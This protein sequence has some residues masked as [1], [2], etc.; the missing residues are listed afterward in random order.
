MT[1]RKT[2]GNPSR[3]TAADLSPE[4]GRLATTVM[5]NAG[6]LDD[7]RRYAERSSDPAAHT[8]LAAACLSR[9]DYETAR[10]AY[11][12]ALELGDFAPARQGAVNLLIYLAAHAAA[13]EE[14]DQASQHLQEAI[15]AHPENPVVRRYSTAVQTAALMRG[16]SADQMEEA[17]PHLEKLQL[18]EPGRADLAHQLAMMYHRR[19]IE[20]EGTNKAAKRDRAWELAFAN[21]GLVI[22]SDEYWR[23]WD[24]A[25]EFVYEKQID[26]AEVEKLRHETIGKVIKDLHNQYIKLYSDRGQ[27]AHLERHKGLRAAWALELVMARALHETIK[28]LQSKNRVPETA[29]ACG[30]LMWKHL[31]IVD[32]VEAT[33]RA[34]LKL[35]P[36]FPA[37]QELLNGLTPVGMAR[38][39]IEEGQLMEAIVLLEE[40]LE[41]AARDAAARQLI[42]TA[43]MRYAQTVVHQNLEEAVGYWVK[44]KSFGAAAADVETEISDAVFREAKKREEAGELAQA[45]SVLRLGL[46]HAPNSKLLRDKLAQIANQRA[47]GV[48]NELGQGPTPTQVLSKLQS[49]QQILQAA[50]RL[51]GPNHPVI[52][53]SLNELNQIQAQ[54]A[55]AMLVNKVNGAIERA[56]NAVQNF[57]PGENYYSVSTELNAALSIL[58]S[59]AREAPGEQAIRKHIVDLKTGIAN[60]AQA[61]AIALN[62]QAVSIVNSLQYELS[63]AQYMTYTQRQNVC[64]Q[65]RQAEGLLTQALNLSSGETS[66]R[67]NLDQI[68]LM[69][70]ALDR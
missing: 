1:M 39:L 42:A 21:W 28:L 53:K 50:D 6:R 2:T 48:M 63:R 65:L 37:A 46:K 15:R 35:V 62:G 29:I 49:A 5:L 4:L 36:S 58:E 25:R 52:V 26:D 47:I 16:I 3:K 70:K 8:A 66:V 27:S 41:K 40:H 33:A 9:E 59:A 61:E 31:G 22:E 54:M 68:R 23:Q 12:K 7:A 24:E 56:N 34:A 17:I 60:V 11:L 55:S 19:A 14:W 32:K 18:E 57:R 44:A 45:D 20:M 64:N 51:V 30:P 13:R 43:Y 38:V 69:I 10:D 67:Q